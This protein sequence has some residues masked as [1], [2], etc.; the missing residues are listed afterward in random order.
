MGDGEQ[1]M[2]ISTKKMGRNY[3][4]S[5]SNSLGYVS[6]FTYI[7]LTLILTRAIYS[8]KPYRNDGRIAVCERK[9]VSDLD[10]TIDKKSA[11]IGKNQHSN[12][13]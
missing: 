9:R 1:P 7:E 5:P 6:L 13:C 12:S 11:L 3:L 2:S 8:T 4:K 10:K